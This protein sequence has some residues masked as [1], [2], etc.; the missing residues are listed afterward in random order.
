MDAGKRLKPPG[1]GIPTTT[2]NRG[3]EVCE[4]R[5]N[6][7]LHAERGAGQ[8][9]SDLTYLRPRGPWVYLTGIWPEGHGLGL[10]HGQGDGSYYDTRPQ[11]GLYK[12]CGSGQSA[13]SVDLFNNPVSCRGRL[14]DTSLVDL[15]NFL[16]KPAKSTVF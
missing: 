7:E 11:D 10:Q 4:N 1:G 2:S 5:L 13:V 6:R 16:Q 12:P 15:A 3:L 8:W 9:V 14:S